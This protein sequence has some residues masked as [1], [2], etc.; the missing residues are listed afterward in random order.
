MERLHQCRLSIGKAWLDRP[1]DIYKW[2]KNDYQAPL[3]MLKDPQTGGPTANVDGMDEIVH[4]SWDK[5][6]CKYVHSPK[7]HPDGFV[8]KSRNFIKHNTDMGATPLTGSRL[9][10]CFRKMGIHAATGL[11]GWCVVDV[12][13]LPNAMLDMLAHLLTHIES[14]GL[15]PRMLARGFV[16]F[17]RSWSAGF[18]SR[19]PN[20][21]AG[22]GTLA[23]P[24]PMPGAQGVIGGGGGSQSPP[25]HPGGR[26]PCGGCDGEGY[27]KQPLPLRAAAGGGAGGAP[28]STGE[29]GHTPHS[30]DEGT[31][32]G[33]PGGQQGADLAAWEG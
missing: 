22:R 29:E 25:P 14:I 20:D 28:R 15:W 9:R 24:G 33:A 32:S 2:I 5:V 30:R 18:H 26:R 1:K 11:D 3:V 10:K 23:H 8:Q 7:P 19:Q 12:L 13:C 31:G 21:L 16:S 4:E 17:V 6:M 27:A